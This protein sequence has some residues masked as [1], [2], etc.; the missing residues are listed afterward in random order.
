MF[1]E[2]ADGVESGVMRN[3]LPALQIETRADLHDFIPPDALV[4]TRIGSATLTRHGM[5]TR[6]IRPSRSSGL[7]SRPTPRSS[8][9][10]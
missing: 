10:I 3:G 2:I 4:R 1:E 7:Y 8:S 9:T 5:S 6:S